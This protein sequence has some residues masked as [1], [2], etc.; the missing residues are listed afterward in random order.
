MLI[1][2]VI[3]CNGL[4]MMLMPVGV[5]VTSVMVLGIASLS[6]GCELLIRRETPLVVVP[7]MVEGVLVAI[8]VSLTVKRV[9]PESGIVVG[10][11]LWGISVS[12]GGRSALVETWLPSHGS[13][14]V[15]IRVEVLVAKVRRGKDHFVIEASQLALVNTHG[16]K[17]QR[18][19]LVMVEGEI[20]I[21]DNRVPS[22]LSRKRLV[23][24]VEGIIVK[25][26]KVP[27]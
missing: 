1:A 26:V 12:T 25:A 2:G 16:A 13:C 3:N 11:L 14:L 9:L 7:M 5:A 24:A 20:E 10:R 4:G 21:S 27:S 23:A 6:I 15:E 19:I 8:G 22:P 18:L 17:S